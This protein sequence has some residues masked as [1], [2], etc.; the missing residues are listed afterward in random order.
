MDGFAA[1]WAGIFQQ[2]RQ[3]HSTWV[4]LGLLAATAAALLSCAGETA[5]DPAAGTRRMVAILDSLDANTDPEKNPYANTI[6]VA[7]WRQRLA[8][9]RASSPNPNSQPVLKTRFNLANELLL[10]GQCEEAVLALQQLQQDVDHPG[11]LHRIQILLGLSY[12][13][14]GERDNCIH[15]HSVDSCLMPI[16]GAGVHEIERGSRGAIREF[17]AVLERNPGDLSA[18][19][20]LNIAYMTLG[21]YPDEVPAP[22]LIPAQVFESDYDIKRFRDV[23]PA[24]GIDVMSLS[25]GGIMEDFD[26]DGYLDIFASS[27]GLRDQSRYFRNNADGSFADLTEEAGLLGITGGLN[28]MLTDYD[29]DGYSD[30]LI[31]RGAWRNRPPATDGGR[32]PNSL[33]RNRSG[34]GF[35][36]VTEAAGMLSFHPTQTGT[37]GDYDNDG[38]TDLYIGN[39]TVSD[40]VNP[41]ELY[42]NRGD[43]TF[44]NVAAEAGVAVEAYVKAVIWGDYDNDG[45]LDLYLSRLRTHQKNILFHNE[46]E[47]EAGFHHFTDVSAAAGVP[48]PPISF[49]GWFW[50]YDNDGWLDIFVSGYSA[51]ASEVAA[52]Y[53]GLPHDGERPRLYRNNGDGTFSDVTREAR[54]DK[55]LL[56]MGSNFGDL[57]SDGWLDCYIGT[58]SPGLTSVMPNRMFRNA[59]GRF[60]QD[61]TTSGGFGTLQKGH[62]VAFGDIDQDGDQD[63]YATMGG[64]YVGDIAHNLLFE[65]PGHGNHWI[66]LKLEGVRSNRAAIG[67]R[68]KV[69]VTT[70]TG[71][72]DIYA[73][74]SSGS[75]FGASSFR[76]EIGLGQAT[77]IRAIEIYWP[78][79]DERQLFKDVEMDQVLRIVE[80]DPVPKPIHLK[81]FE[82]GAATPA[83]GP[84]HAQ[85][86]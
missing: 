22:Y 40:Q 45:R 12:L 4:G 28:A 26:G 51:G 17:E 33:L 65:N 73:T 50:D 15:Q 6:K 16:R 85:H 23:A 25:G 32:Y 43:G 27:W 83:P 59:E 52:D 2:R 14:L 67:A 47:G 5:R 38:W 31:L 7:Y 60:F 41:C 29:N 34:K 77:S 69:S 1:M 9:M 58:G 48:G 64:A 70:A 53:M 10:D 49:P 13:R 3:P 62:G 80:G 30:I 78:A 19:W 71:E 76:Q 66:I 56:T 61:V 39:E 72:R 20:L 36:D 54:L 74:V 55:A 21:E 84:E 82:L 46:G 63:V 86:P 44:E 81:S 79:S 8:D 37:W 11:A 35:L 75:S 24:V 57:D 42:R 18:R 68:I